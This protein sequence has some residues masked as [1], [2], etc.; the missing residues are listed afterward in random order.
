MTPASYRNGGLGAEIIYGFGKTSVG[1]AL[2]AATE[3]GLYLL[4][5]GNY[6]SELTAELEGN[7]PNAGLQRDESAV[8][9]YLDAIRALTDLGKAPEISLTLDTETAAFQWKAWETL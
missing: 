7:Y 9:T 4:G 2:V 1:Q 8:G 6:K 3:H 5:F